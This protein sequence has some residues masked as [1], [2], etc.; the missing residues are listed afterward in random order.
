MNQF[1][2]VVHTRD[3][4]Y[5]G[6]LLAQGGSEARDALDKYFTEQGEKMIWLELKGVTS[7]TFTIQEIDRA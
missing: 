5:F 7:K 2:F 6:C 4:K 3:K 1:L